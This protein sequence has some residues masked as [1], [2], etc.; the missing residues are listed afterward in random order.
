MK[1]SAK[2]ILTALAAFAA[3]AA[4]VF[5]FVRVQ[6]K[7]GGDA[8]AESPAASPVQLKRGAN[9]VTVI[10]LDAQTQ[11]RL[12]LK[13]EAPAA[14]LWQ[15]EIH[16]VGRV[17]DPLAFTAA[18]ADYESA[19]AAATVSQSELDRAEKLAEQ[20]NVS[21]RALE[22]A[23]AAAARDA[24]ALKAARAKFTADWG[25]QLAAQTNL[26]AFAEKL[27]TDD[28]AF[29]KLLLPV[30]TFANPLPSA[31]T[32]FI[33]GY[34]TNSVAAEFADNLGIDPATQVQT[35]LF[36]VKHSLR[37]S[38][39]VTAQM[40]IPGEPVSGVVVPADAL[41]RYEGRG[42][43]Y[44]QTGTNDFT[45]AEIPLDRPEAN[46]WFVSGGLTATNPVIVNGAQTVLSAELSSGN[47]N[48]GSR[49]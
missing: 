41:L 26:A 13:T 40:Q 11:Q 46:G 32:I 21:P 42:W 43:V 29:V 27:Q 49:D 37:P 25:V 5:Y 24:L 22:A 33:F 18:A 8:G 12:G 3:G 4:L 39:S 36:S 31:A 1:T 35:L 38:I 23:Q 14:K 48:S 28:L 6:P 47:F 44:V 16:A 20:G 19:R 45:R 17:V 30:G 9:G 34:E 2:I 10:V 15:P 7:S